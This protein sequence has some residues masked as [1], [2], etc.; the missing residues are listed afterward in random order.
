MSFL[1]SYYKFFGFFLTVSS[2]TNH[3]FPDPNLVFM[4]F[5]RKQEVFPVSLFKMFPILTILLG[6]CP[7]RIN[8]KDTMLTFV[9]IFRK[10]SPLWMGREDRAKQVLSWH[11][12]RRRN[13]RRRKKSSERRTM[14]K[15]KKMTRRRRAGG[16]EPGGKAGRTPGPWFCFLKFVLLF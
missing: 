5:F 1:S 7:E 11:P 8:F 4:S 9:Y 14:R 2:F 12:G 3:T 15:S 6:Q 10:F 13:I 16:E